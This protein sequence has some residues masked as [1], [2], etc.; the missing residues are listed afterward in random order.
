MVGFQLV[1]EVWHLKALKLY[2]SVAFQRKKV[3]HFENKSKCFPKKYDLLFYFNICMKIIDFSSIKTREHL[4]SGFLYSIVTNKCELI[5]NFTMD[6]ALHCW[7]ISCNQ[8]KSLSNCF[9]YENNITKYWWYNMWSMWRWIIC[10][11]HCFLQSHF[12]WLRVECDCV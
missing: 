4:H 7:F 12:L 2:I 10:L 3:W 8:H 1:R 5:R 9:K 11:K 6:V